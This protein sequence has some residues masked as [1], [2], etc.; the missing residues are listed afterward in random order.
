MNQAAFI[1]VMESSN[2][3]PQTVLSSGNA[4]CSD[5]LSRLLTKPECWNTAGHSLCSKQRTN[6][7]H[8][9]TLMSKTF[10]SPCQHNTLTDLDFFQ[11]IHQ[12]L[13]L[14][15][16]SKMRLFPFL[17]LPAPKVPA[18]TTPFS[19]PPSLRLFSQLLYV[20]EHCLLFP[21]CE[22]KTDLL[23]WF[24]FIRSLLSSYC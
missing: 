12:Q 16:C 22:D 9:I 17:V 18:C 23:Q 15:S 11:M 5:F 20:S 4:V 2:W 24:S 7:A 13:S 6:Q 8:Q 3:S 21:C 10:F 19:S 14:K 1:S